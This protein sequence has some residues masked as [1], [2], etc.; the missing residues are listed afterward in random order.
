ME[1]LIRA[2]GEWLTAKEL[3]SSVKR[4]LNVILVFESEFSESPA[5]CQKHTVCF[6]DY[7]LTLQ[8]YQ[9]LPKA[10]AVLETVLLWQACPQTN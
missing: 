8:C 1:E 7:F 9:N 2:S 3:V 5:G 6:L 4:P 10:L